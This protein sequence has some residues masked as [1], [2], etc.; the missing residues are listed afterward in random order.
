MGRL[1]TSL[2][3]SDVDRLVQTEVVNAQRAVDRAIQALR[4]AKRMPTASSGRVSRVMRELNRAKGALS[5]VS[6]V[7]PGID[8][9]DPDLMS[10]DQRALAH[11]QRLEEERALEAAARLQAAVVEDEGPVGDDD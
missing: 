5:N 11:R 4:Q 8:L 9:N 3:K 2:A 6:Y 7:S 10:E 1:R